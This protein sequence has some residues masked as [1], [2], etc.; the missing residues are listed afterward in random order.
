MQDIFFQRDG[1]TL[2]EDALTLSIQCGKNHP[3]PW[4][5]RQ[6]HRSNTARVPKI[7]TYNRGVRHNQ[8]L[9]IT[10]DLPR[11]AMATTHPDNAID[12]P[13]LIFGEVSL[14]LHFQGN[15]I[16]FHDFDE[17]TTQFHP[18]ATEWIGSC[19]QFPNV[20]VRLYVSVFDSDGICGTVSVTGAEGMPLKA[21]LVIGGLK[22]GPRPLDPCFIQPDSIMIPAKTEKVIDNIF[23]VMP[24]TK[25]TPF[26]SEKI[27]INLSDSCGKSEISDEGICFSFDCGQNSTADFSMF[28]HLDELPKKAFLPLSELKADFSQT[29]QYAARLLDTCRVYTPSPL[30]NAAIRHAVLN[31]DYIHVGDAW[32]E[33][34]QWWNCY[35]TNNFQISAAIALGQYDRAKKAL[36]ALGLQEGGYTITTAAGKNAFAEDYPHMPKQPLSF[37]GIPYYIYQ[38]WQYTEAT[39]DLSVLKAVFDRLCAILDGL[40]KACDIN[41]SGLIGW[42][43]GCNPF[44]YQ[45]DHLNLP[46]DATS[47][48]VMMAAMLEKMAE[49]AETIDKK[50]AAAA[51][52]QKSSAMNQAVSER[53]WNE[54]DQCFFSHVD[55]Q[56][57]AHNAHYYTDLIF[58]ALYG[59][60]KDNIQMGGLSHLRRTLLLKS[61]E[62]GELLMRVGDL[63]PDIFGNN[64]IMPTQMA[65]SARAFGKTGDKNTAL[66]LMQAV[67]RSVTVFTE[68]PGSV[69]ERLNDEGK[70]ECNYMFGN[71]CGSFLYTAIDGIFGVS[72]RKLGSQLC[73]SPAL[74]D[75]WE[76]A[77]IDL[78][79]ASYRFT[80]HTFHVTAKSPTIKTLKL[81]FFSD[82]NNPQFQIGEQILT[83]TAIPKF[84]RFLITLTLPLSASEELAV[85]PLFDWSQQA[86]DDSDI[87]VG[88][89]PAKTKTHIYNV[90]NAIPI[91]INTHRNSEYMMAASAWRR[92]RNFSIPLSGLTMEKGSLLTPAG[93]FAL[94]LRPEQK[95]LSFCVIGHGFSHTHSGALV[96]SGFASSQT[97]AVADCISRLDLLY[98]SEVESRLTGDTVGK[99]TLHYTDKDETIPLVV[100]KNISTLFGHF[101]EET[102]RIEVTQ[103]ESPDFASILQIPCDSKRL[104]LSFTV[105]IDRYDTEFALIAAN[106]IL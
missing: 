33:G 101:A 96:P 99:L 67:A 11:F 95:R 106:K 97:F 29:E 82:E 81:S 104:L 61:A 9:L 89:S 48:S 7:Q 102:V 57:A 55:L 65:E 72:L 25:D 32:F 90:S 42:R 92:A 63:K 56:G 38:L 12:P 21:E 26:A 54:Q 2:K 68:S 80:D 1:Y 85:T 51:F 40:F 103:G 6:D 53:L 4:V 52:H 58:P 5:K 39:G 59:E 15:L 91:D 100:G 34:G 3:N 46:G 36:L 98:A 13:F 41:E 79:Y 31:H 47:P 83:G 44:L 8:T 30:L 23:Q 75:E 69:P 28:H 70:G 20:Q 45:A 88:I 66:A 76:N 14:R 10:G 19:K 35:W 50:E 24:L 62:T 71:P 105:S 60:Y 94:S 93:K 78:P 64:N 16:A 18:L 22:V 73:L 17:I 27:C 87:P 77:E 43:H 37:E 86:M 49:L 74:S 84:G